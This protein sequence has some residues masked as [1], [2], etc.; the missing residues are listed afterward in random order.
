MYYNFNLLVTFHTDVTS[1]LSCLYR[2]KKNLKGKGKGMFSLLKDWNPSF[3]PLKLFK[4]LILHPS[5]KKLGRP[6][7]RYFLERHIH[8]I[9]LFLRYFLSIQK[10]YSFM[11]PKNQ[12]SAIFKALVL[13]LYLDPKAPFFL[14]F[15]V[16]K[17]YP[18]KIW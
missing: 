18:S 17:M 8:S 15:F 13:K 12:W 5:K 16:E 1:L 7:I 6:C 11:L 2:K 3:Y 9:Q 4:P 10:S 14:I